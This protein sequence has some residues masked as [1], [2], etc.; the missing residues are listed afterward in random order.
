MHKE[1]Y[2]QKIRN[3]LQDRTENELIFVFEFL[4]RIFRL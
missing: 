3:L 4:Q 1:Q 2:I